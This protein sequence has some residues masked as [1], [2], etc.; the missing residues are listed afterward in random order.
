VA[1]VV[2]TTNPPTSINADLSLVAPPT[3]DDFSP[4]LRQQYGSLLREILALRILNQLRI[5]VPIP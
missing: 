3:L 5:N 4:E 1:N 2:N